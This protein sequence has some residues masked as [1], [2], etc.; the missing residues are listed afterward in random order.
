[1]NI[2]IKLLDL[3]VG[4][5][6]GAMTEYAKRS[7]GAS[8]SKKGSNLFLNDA[9]LEKIVDTLC[10]MRG[11]ALKFGQMLSIQGTLGFHFTLY[12]SFRQL[13]CKS[14]DSEHI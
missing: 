2:F 12:A 3:F 14:E 6:I 13:P 7:L 10:R 8:D 4:L 5:G 1:M 9:N 11:A